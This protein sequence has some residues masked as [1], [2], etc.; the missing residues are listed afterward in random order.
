MTQAILY[1]VATPIGNLGDITIRALEILKSVDVIAAEDTRHTSGLLA[2]FGISKKLFVL[3]QHNEHRS[4]QQLIQRLQAGETIALVTDAGTPA[5]S[6]PG[7]IAVAAAAAAGFKVVPVPGVSAVVAALSASGICANGFTFVGFLPASSS[8]RKKALST[9]LAH[10]YT[11]AFYEAPH[12]VLESMADMGA[13]FGVRNIVIARELTKTFET[14][15]RGS[16]VDALKWLKA[17]VNQQRGEFVLL[18]EP[19]PI[20][21]EEGLNDEYIRVLKTLLATLPLKQAVTL[22][23]EITG[24]KKNMLYDFALEL[25]N[26]G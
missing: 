24:A 12:R 22:A 2:H 21:E 18:V 1:V 20:M 10:P 13:M 16:L 25:K 9:L 26:N 11:L 6:D 3:H 5:V 23:T 15:F 17:D 19:A 7:A 14:F 8:A 4:S